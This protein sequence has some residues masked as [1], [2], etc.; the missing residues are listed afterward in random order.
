MR[1]VARAGPGRRPSRLTA[2]ASKRLHRLLKHDLGRAVTRTERGTWTTTSGLPHEIRLHVQAGVDIVRVSAGMAVGVKPTKKLLR[3]LNDLNVQRSLSRRIA[4]DDK[5]VVV[6]E[7][8]LAS[9]RKGDLEHLVSMVL[10]FA[11]LDAPLLAEFGGR[12]V[13]DPPP[14]LAPDLDA[15]VGSWEELLRA[16]RTATLRELTVWLDD[17]AGCDCWID[18]DDDGVTPVVSGIGSVCEYPFRLDELRQ[19][20]EDLQDEYGDADDD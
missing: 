14:A 4:A 1:R 11:R 5:V 13:T 18:R 6:A 8:P 3:A 17:V 19:A 15:V 20:A 10:C 9:V 12:L 2:V 7:L 16:S